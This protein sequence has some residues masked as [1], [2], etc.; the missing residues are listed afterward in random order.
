MKRIWPSFS[1]ALASSI[2]FSTDCSEPGAAQPII[3][4]I[5]SINRLSA[6]RIVMAASSSSRD[7]AA[8]SGHAPDDSGALLRERLDLVFTLRFAHS[9]HAEVDDV[10]LVAVGAE[11]D[12]HRALEPAVLMHRRRTALPH[13]RE[14]RS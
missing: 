11:A 12:V 2:G 3:D 10:E 1:S 6:I 9:H 5:E 14:E 8:G 4:S 7:R 13:V